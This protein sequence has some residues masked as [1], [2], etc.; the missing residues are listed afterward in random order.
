MILVLA[1]SVDN[2]SQP[3]SSQTPTLDKTG[4]V[5]ESADRKE[6][7]DFRALVSQLDLQLEFAN[8]LQLAKRERYY[9]AITRAFDRDHLAALVASGGQAPIGR[10]TLKMQAAHIIPLSLNMF[11]DGSNHKAVSLICVVWSVV[12]SRAVPLSQSTSIVNAAYTWDML[13]SWTQIDLR[14]LV[15][16]KITSPENG[17]YMTREDHDGFGSFEFY[18]DKEAVSPS[19]YL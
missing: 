4:E 1:I 16:A 13:Q 7:R 12:Y 11:D 14:G 2:R 6:Q 9:C 8:S 3:S 17:I 18:L 5:I 15:G 19:I 10:T